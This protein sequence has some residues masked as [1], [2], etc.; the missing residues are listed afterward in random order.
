MTHMSV[1]S[2]SNGAIQHGWFAIEAG[3]REEFQEKWA[4]CK[5]DSRLEPKY[6]SLFVIEVGQ[7][8]S[9]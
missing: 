9:T 5:D 6:S 1:T 7:A 3:E 4:E 8:A 2:G